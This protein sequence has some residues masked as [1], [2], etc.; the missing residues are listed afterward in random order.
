MK[1][2]KT[3]GIVA[4]CGSIVLTLG[5]CGGGGGGS[6]TPSS[7]NPPDTTGGGTGTH[8]AGELK[9]V[10]VGG[11]NVNMRWCPAGTFSMGI[12]SDSGFVVPEWKSHQ[13][14]L[15]KGFWICETEVTQQLWTAVMGTNPST[16][17]S[18]NFPVETVSQN[19]CNSFLSKITISGYTVSLPT[20]AQ[21]EYAYRAGTTTDFYNGNYDARSS[22]S[23]PL[24][25]VH[26]SEI[27][28]YNSN[29]LAW[30][31]PSLVSCAVGTKTP[32]AWHIS[33]MAGNVQ[34]LTSDSW[35]AYPQTSEIDP[36][37]TI[38][39]SV[40]YRGGDYSSWV[41]GCT[42]GYREANDLKS[43]KE[44]YIG[45]RFIMTENTVSSIVEV[46]N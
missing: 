38:G 10:N 13:V 11:I 23:A 5:G 4:L 42:A 28:V 8:L 18:P 43:D 46:N 22:T 19:D 31:D 3:M 26:L 17:K 24:T 34:E 9:T 16:N 37:Y 21:W 25:A 27:A 30:N 6:S 33:D 39:N 29:K 40:V 41:I 45:F 2:I 1:S 12:P 20:E 15:T 36:H 44:D 32:N 35:R 7:S 14:T